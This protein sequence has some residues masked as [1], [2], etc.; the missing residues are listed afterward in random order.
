MSIFFGIYE[1]EALHQWMSSTP[2]EYSSFF[3]ASHVSSS[4]FVRSYSSKS[5]AEAAA[6]ICHHPRSQLTLIADVR[7]INSK[8]LRSEFNFKNTNDSELILE[9]Y[10][11]LGIQCVNYL[12]GHFVFA[13]W[14]Q[15]K[16]QLFLACDSQATTRTLYY[17]I[18][19]GRLYF[20]NLI[21]PLFDHGGRPKSLNSQYIA[22]FLTRAFDGDDDTAF[23]SIKRLPSGHYLTFD[24]N[25]KITYTRYWCPFEIQQNPLRLPTRKAY[26]TYFRE[27]FYEVIHDHLLA[28]EGPIGCHLSGGLDSS[29]VTAIA[30][31]IL[32]DSD[33][34]LTAYSYI[35][36]SGATKTPIKF[37]NYEDSDFIEAFIREYRHINLIY[38]QDD[39]KSLFD[40]HQ[41][42]LPWLD[43][44]MHIP[45]NALWLIACIE[46]ASQIGIKSLFNGV[47]GNITLSW[48]GANH[49]TVANQMMNFLRNQFN[50]IY[51]GEQIKRPWRHFSAMSDKLAW[52]TNWKF[53]YRNIRAYEHS[54]ME[55]NQHRE[56]M[57]NNLNYD[58][59]ASFETVCRLLYNVESIDPTAD[60]RIVEF[61]L[62]TPHDVFNNENG[63][64]LLV[65]ESLRGILPE[66]IRNRTTRGLQSSDWYKKI[67]RKKDAIQQQLFGWKQTQV[68]DYIDL[69]HLI[70]QFK[71]WDY[72]RVASSQKQRYY[73]YNNS[74]HLKLLFALEMGYFIEWH[75]K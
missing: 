16:H 59:S 22:Q 25:K 39:H 49:S 1:Y 24:R 38:I 52:N 19:N 44:P 51:Y 12:L 13:L 72:Q 47:M 53:R 11:R 68:E 5:Q 43:V 17:S 58:C 37:F 62:Q 31:S 50:K 73:F 3:Q 45:T 20:A 35:P 33:Q 7:L 27:L 57:F 4:I 75:S 10:Q 15:K 32:R 60:K 21:K 54:L 63:S 29:S 6:T 30:A 67:E 36:T 69:D 46:N 34:K 26:Y 66:L 42:F 40:Y 18:E 65:R 23:S 61:C 48:I 71:R 70:K 9:A 55:K 2:N 28:C 56:L 74:Y 8:A 14:D 64:R 41:T